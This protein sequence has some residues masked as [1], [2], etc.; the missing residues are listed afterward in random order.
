MDIMCDLTGRYDP[1]LTNSP[2]S[3]NSATVAKAKGESGTLFGGG[4]QTSTRNPTLGGSPTA[5]HHNHFAWL[6]E[7]YMVSR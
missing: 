2:Q 3:R 7:H 1:L 4:A 5:E 6:L